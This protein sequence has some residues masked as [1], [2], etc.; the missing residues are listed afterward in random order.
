MGM[1]YLYKVDHFG[2]YVSQVLIN[3]VVILR[4][5][6]VFFTPT[7]SKPA[8]LHLYNTFYFK[9]N[10]HIADVISFTEIH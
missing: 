4:A 10:T 3:Y 1:Q 2:K 9:E 7:I 6:L 5:V 8:K